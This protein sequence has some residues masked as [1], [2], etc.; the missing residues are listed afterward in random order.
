MN[1]QTRVLLRKLQIL[2]LVLEPLFI[3]RLI[4]ANEFAD[5]DFDILAFPIK[6]LEVLADPFLNPLKEQILGLLCV[7]DFV[8]RLGYF[9]LRLIS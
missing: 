6:V 3:F 5:F 9:Q 4:T 2:Q 7:K 8:C 1:L